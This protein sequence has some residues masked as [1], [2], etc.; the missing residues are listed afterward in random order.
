MS[1]GARVGNG[2]GQI[3]GFR[4]P[5]GLNVN[6]KKTFARL[7]LAPGAAATIAAGAVV[8]GFLAGDVLSICSGNSTRNN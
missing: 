3:S 2:P 7:S 5:G 4:F 1:S 6:R 8:L